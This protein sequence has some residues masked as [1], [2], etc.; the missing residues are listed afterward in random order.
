MSQWRLR[1]RTELHFSRLSVS[2]ADAKAVNGGDVV[3][4]ICSVTPAAATATE[5]WSVPD[6]T[7]AC[8][9]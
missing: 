1:G 6:L 9:S 2:E 8:P 3:L 5:R 4:D 7:T